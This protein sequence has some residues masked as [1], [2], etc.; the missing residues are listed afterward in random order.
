MS[1]RPRR[2]GGAQVRAK[3]AAIDESGSGPYGGD[4]PSGGGARQPVSLDATILAELRSLSATVRAG[5]QRAVSAVT[6]LSLWQAYDEAHAHLSWWRNVRSLM[7]PTV[8]AFGA[9]E[10][11]SLTR[12]DWRDHVAGRGLRRGSP[13]LLL[14]RCRSMLRWAKHE[15]LLPSALEHDWFS[16]ALPKA[17]P[18]RRSELAGDQ[19][20]RLLACGGAMWS[21]FF[22][23]AVDTSLRTSEVLALRWE[24]LDLANSRARLPHGDVK[25]DVPRDVPLS[26]RSVARLRKLKRR[27]DVPWVFPS[28]RT[29]RPLTRRWA[30]MHF[31]KLADALGIEA[32]PGDESMH[33]HD[34]RGTS[35]ARVVRAGANLRE[36]M[37]HLGVKSAKTA[38]KYIQRFSVEDR[39]RHHDL[40][41]R[42]SRGERVVTRRMR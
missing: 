23:V 31:R 30:H 15:R 25:N 19:I 40:V 5:P 33:L 14:K 10:A 39:E 13:L 12:K 3:S 18:E 29:D 37:A 2:T 6:V 1:P 22:C 34:A 4:A 8:A 16:V 41:E 20:D 32:A 9:R 28:P 38:D 11:M 17:P 36:V 24:W 21:A 35:A 7:A 26:S 27:R 42:A